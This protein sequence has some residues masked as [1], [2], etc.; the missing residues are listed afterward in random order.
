MGG[1]GCFA[2]PQQP[3]ASGGSGDLRVLYTMTAPA[4]PFTGQSNSSLTFQF[5]AGLPSGALLG[6]L[7]VDGVTSIVGVD[8]TQHPPVFTGPMVTI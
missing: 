3:Y 4:L 8:W 1:A 5:P 2:L 7:Q 6:R